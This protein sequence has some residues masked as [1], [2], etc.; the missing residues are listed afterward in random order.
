MIE[1]QGL[2]KFYD[3]LEALSEVS[4]SIAEGEIL[5]LVGPNGA[6]KTTCLRILCGMIPPMRGLVRLPGKCTT[7]AFSTST[8]TSISRSIRRATS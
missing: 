6:G 8:R 4:F 3:N 7:K 5:G 1:A 2:T